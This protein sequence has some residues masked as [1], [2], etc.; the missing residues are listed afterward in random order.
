MNKY[1]IVESEFNGANIWNSEMTSCVGTIRRLHNG[2]FRINIQGMMMR[3]ANMESAV[4][5]VGEYIGEAV[6]VRKAC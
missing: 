5:R 4:E 1:L 2:S 3:A 6:E